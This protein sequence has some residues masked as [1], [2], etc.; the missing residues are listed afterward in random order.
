MQRCYI[1]A[2][3]WKTWDVL[4]SASSLVVVISL[5]QNFWMWK[6]LPMQSGLS[7]QALR[8]K[9]DDQCLHVQFLSERCKGKL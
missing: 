4:V 7:T 2:R 1:C 6:I 8:G 5:L 3:P 9:S